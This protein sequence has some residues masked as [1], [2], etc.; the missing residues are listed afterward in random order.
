MRNKAIS[1]NI[2]INWC[3]YNR[4]GIGGRRVG[5]RAMSEMR[6]LATL[7]KPYCESRLNYPQATVLTNSRTRS[8]Q[9]L[10]YTIITL[11]RMERRYCIQINWASIF[12]V[13]FYLLGI[14]YK[15][16]AL[17]YPNLSSLINY[18]NPGLVLNEDRV[19]TALVGYVKYNIGI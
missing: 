1:H 7:T 19:P 9:G 5:R 8:E 17:F 11:F 4:V 18:Q 16:S 14:A 15:I 6:Q 2:N 12:N 3:I 10:G 13:R